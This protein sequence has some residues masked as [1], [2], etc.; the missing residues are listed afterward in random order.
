MAERGLNRRLRIGL[1]R[2]RRVL[3]NSG[4]AL[5]LGSLL[6]GIAAGY[7]AIGIRLG[8]QEVQAL[9]YGF[10]DERFHS[11]AMLLD[12]WA[13]LLAPV[14][15]GLLVGLVVHFLLPG[16]RPQSFAAVIEATALRDGRIRLRDGLLNAGVSVLSL[17]CGASAGREGPVVHLGATLAGFVS[18]SLGVSRS[19]AMSLIAC[20]VAS[21]TAA[22][23]NAPMAGV[24]LA[25]EVILG[26][27]ALTA[28]APVV[29]AAVAG[30]I[31]CRIHIGDFPAFFIPRYDLVTFFE[32]PAFLLLGMVSAAVAIVYMWS[33]FYAQDTIERLSGR[34]RIPVWARPAI[35]G[36]AIG[37]VGIAF[38]QILGVGYEAADEALRGAFSLDQLLVLLVLKTAAVAV[39][40]GCRF[41]GGV[42]SPALYIG[43]MAGGAFGLIAAMAFPDHASSHGLYAVIGMGAV[44]AAVLG[45]PLATTLIVFEL[46]DDW[47]LA[48][49]LMVAVAVATLICSQV[50]ARS[51]FSLQL[52][53]QGLDLVGGRER[54][55]LRSRKVADAMD[56]RFER[57]RADLSLSTVQNAMRTAHYSDFVVVDE[58]GRLVGRLTFPELQQALLEAEEERPPAEAAGGGDAA[59]AD[60]PS[61]PPEPR[62]RT[63]ADIARR[64]VGFLAADET[65]ADALDL[66]QATGEPWLPVVED[67][68]SLRVIGIIRQA[69]V[70][71]AYNRALLQARA[72]ERGE[73]LPRGQGQSQGRS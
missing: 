4:L 42:F 41:G 54:R 50:Y 67:R 66:L 69:D 11:R 47:R 23:F 64:R 56:R 20:G 72:E 28:F 6:V 58:E 13:I 30:T 43:A 36:L 32:F 16:Q 63:A 38:P 49:A 18:R 53:R 51:F 9:F 60:P 68:D 27:Y 25:L 2:S 21:A 39:S 15:G 55:L 24:F 40:L 65:L 19:V 73:D 10:P 14:A 70:L 57:L 7:G 22:S 35:G 44:T 34:W 52:R 59:G 48:A 71:L 17:G 37:A 62:P 33:I 1:G 45:A 46:T 12:W 31:I 29:I 3:R 61:P 8:I 26:H 5:W